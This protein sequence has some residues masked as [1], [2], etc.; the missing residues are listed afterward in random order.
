MCVG[1]DSTF[2]YNTL[3]KPNRTKRNDKNENF[4]LFYG[5]I[6][7]HICLPEEQPF[8]VVVV[9]VCWCAGIYDYIIEKKRRR[10]RFYIW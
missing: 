9:V 1:V 5:N 10:L 2:S 4:D 8:F 7:F 6:H 3:L